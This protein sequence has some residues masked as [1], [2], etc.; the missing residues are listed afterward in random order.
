M[1]EQPNSRRESEAQESMPENTDSTRAAEA[2]LR[3]A[4]HLTSLPGTD[5]ADIEDFAAISEGS[6]KFDEVDDEALMRYFEAF[7]IEA[8]LEAFEEG[9]RVRA[10]ANPKPAVGAEPDSP[11]VVVI[12]RRKWRPVAWAAVAAAIVLG[13]SILEIG[14]QPSVHP[15]QG[16]EPNVASSLQPERSM[17]P[18]PDLPKQD[19]E[20]NVASSLQPERSMA[21]ALDL[22][23]VP[24]AAPS[25][26]WAKVPPFDA[27]DGKAW[28]EV[29]APLEQRLV[30]GPLQ[31]S[32]TLGGGVGDGL[33]FRL[34][35][36]IVRS[37]IHWGSG[38][39]AIGDGWV[40]TNYH[41]VAGAVQLAAL[42]AHIPSVDV[43]TVRA[44]DDDIKSQQA[45]RAA[46]YR[47]DPV[48]DLAL[49]KL[50]GPDV[51][52]KD[53]EYLRPTSAFDQTESCYTVA[54]QDG[55][56][57]W[58]LRRTEISRVFEFPS[59]FQPG[60]VGSGDT[61]HREHAFLI[62][63][64]QSMTPGD[65]GEPLLNQ[66]GELIGIGFA[67]PANRKAGTTAWYIAARDIQR[68]LGELPVSPE[69]TP[70]DVMTA[71]FAE[72]TLLEPVL[73]TTEKANAL[74]LRYIAG[75]GTDA[76]AAETL[77]VDLDHRDHPPIE[78]HSPIPFGIWGTEEA[79][80]YRFDAFVTLRA[81]GVIA[82]GYTNREGTVD[83]I[84]IG[85]TIE[86]AQVIWRRG[87]TGVWDV[88]R[89]SRTVP[90]IDPARIGDAE[91][92]G[93]FTATIEAE[94][95]GRT[96]G[97]PRGDTAGR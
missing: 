83:E 80:G 28:Q 46:V 36:V 58:W 73:I 90:L 49:L 9:S 66:N 55:G 3:G 30:P 24:D 13:A 91:R 38:V 5:P 93:R 22:R 48:R 39:L 14:R 77:F 41:V 82:F 32:K 8:V 64:T 60:S 40:L 78:P 11:E 74:L 2:I 27:R 31:T 96:Q 51:G 26:S 84:R 20:P 23:R 33:H 1:T 19:R 70:F 18:G 25:L 75:S 53:L 10:H 61:P 71:G 52:L 4:R 6:I 67:S 89:P 16:Q 85:K 21:P 7:G 57:G 17:A 81:D 72:S 97:A 59:Q 63:T 88:T 65:S 76:R 94:F 54:V 79:G 44:V 87:P 86:L 45:I 56:F 12:P 62:E 50:E 35:T 69:R 68:F 95:S 15:K 92:Q 29:G 34:A 42:D 37:G 47:I 43:I